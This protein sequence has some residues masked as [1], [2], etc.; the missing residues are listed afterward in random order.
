MIEHT[1]NSATAE[2][3]LPETFS[4]YKTRC[5]LALTMSN[6]TV[7]GRNKI[8]ALI[9]YLGVEVLQANNLK[10]GISV[11]VGVPIRLAVTMGYHRD[12]RIHSQLSIFDSEMR[13]RTWLLIRVIDLILAGQTGIPPVI[14]RGLGDTI[15]PRNLFDH[16]LGPS[17]TVLPPPR[18]ESQDRMSNISYM[19]SMEKMLSMAYE[20]TDIASE[21]IL[22]PERTVRLNERLEATWNELSLPFYTRASTNEDD[23]RIK[24]LSLEMTRQRACCILHRQYLVAP[25]ADRNDEIFR[26]ACVNSARRILECQSELFQGIFGMPQNRH[27]AWFG[28]SRSVSDCM[29][30][31]MVICLEVINRSKTDHHMNEAIRAELIELLKASR[32]SWNFCPRPSPETAKAAEI[33]AMMLSLVEA[34]RMKSQINSSHSTLSSMQNSKHALQAPIS[35]DSSFSEPCIPGLFSNIQ[36]DGSTIELFDWVWSA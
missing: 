34:D 17:L 16:D 25:R 14:M 8:E 28:V 6:Y 2:M 30:A 24:L 19:I 18:R 9:V 11:L 31:A 22:D 4:L 21:G 10:T 32:A 20:I 1:N 3:Q 33:V 15:N 7:P 36:N 27:R 29:T 23:T 12:P 35:A 5:A 26:A 13:R